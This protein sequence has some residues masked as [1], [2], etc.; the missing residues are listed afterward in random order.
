MGGMSMNYALPATVAFNFKLEGASNPRSDPDM[1]R[2]RF[3]YKNPIAAAVWI[4]VLTILNVYGKEPSVL[5][6][7]YNAFA[8]IVSKISR[9]MGRGGSAQID[10][11][12]QEDRFAALGCDPVIL[13]ILK[14][15]T[16]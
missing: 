10:R 5:F 11:D 9:R 13:L 7:A 6:A 16:G 8:Q 12:A 14:N 2:R 3:G 4:Q 1:M 15:H